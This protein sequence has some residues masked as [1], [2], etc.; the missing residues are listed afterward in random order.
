MLSAPFSVFVFGLTSRFLRVRAQACSL[1]PALLGQTTDAGV[2]RDRVAQESDI[3]S[4]Q[5]YSK[6][7]SARTSME[8][9]DPSCPLGP[10]GD[11][12]RSLRLQEN[13]TSNGGT[14]MSRARR[15]WRRC[16][17]DRVAVLRMCEQ[18]IAVVRW[19]AAGGIDAG[20]QPHHDVVVLVH[21]PHR[22]FA[23]RR[24]VDRRKH[25]LESRSC[26]PPS[27]V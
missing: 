1:T 17:V 23:V 20:R 16:R 21:E 3:G 26:Q 4:A 8:S 7:V 15:A 19:R 25:G 11:M 12:C 6:V 27:P 22:E 10:V 13:Q 9:P 5:P 14:E 24:C 18:E 2:V